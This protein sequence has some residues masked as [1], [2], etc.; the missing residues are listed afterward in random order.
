MFNLKNPV[1][2]EFGAGTL[3]LLANKVSHLGK[4]ALL[5]T[6]RSSAK[7]SGAQDRV[8]RLLTDSMI[9]VVIF[10]QVT[11]NPLASTVTAGARLTIESSCDFVIGLGG[12]SAID[13]AK[14][15]AVMAV[16]PGVITDYQPGGPLSLIIPQQALPIVAITTT[17]GTGTEINRYFVITNDTTHEKPG[18]GYACSYPTVSIVD[19]ELMLSLPTASTLDTG[20]DVLFHAMESFVSK[21]AT[22]FSDMLAEQAM[23]LVLDNIQKAAGNGQNL[24]ARTQMAWANTLAGWAIDLAGTVGIHSLAH[25]ISGH[26]NAT[27]AKSLAA[28]GPAYF[29]YNQTA[30]IPKYAQLAEI[31]G[32]HDHDF[33]LSDDDKAARVGQLLHHILKVLGMPLS[34]LDLGVSEADLDRLVTDTL[35]TMRG[36]LDNNIKPL[37]A[38]DLKAIYQHAMHYHPV[39]HHCDCH[40]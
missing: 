21:G 5:V 1:D 6:G 16:N 12:G 28:V 34:I 11:P 3:N 10:D 33:E 9:D 32:L 29:D 2:L 31:L 22:R 8:I 35:A 18:F 26:F 7:T 23:D 27:H 14:A 40:E 39:E 4:K 20:V 24:E 30:N 25:P 17:A 19:P 37:N 15:I 38:D 13:A 36:G